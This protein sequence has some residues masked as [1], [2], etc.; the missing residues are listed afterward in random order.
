MAGQ[1]WAF[2]RLTDCDRCE[3]N[4]GCSTLL[5]WP[6]TGLDLNERPL[7]YEPSLCVEYGE[8]VEKKAGGSAIFAIDTIEIVTKI[9]TTF[10]LL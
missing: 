4:L 6:V 7:G 9:V 5:F 2:S 3:N 10:F 1:F 8:Y